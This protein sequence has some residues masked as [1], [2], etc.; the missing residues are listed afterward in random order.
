M[1]QKINP[2]GF[3]VGISEAWKSRWYVNNKKYGQYLLEDVKLRQFLMERLKLA[4]I[5]TVE[6]ERLI[7]QMRLVIHV[8]RPGVVIGRGGS[9]LEELK[10]MIVA[11]IGL[12]EAEKNLR[13]EVVEVKEAD[14]SALLVA[15]RVANELERRF[16]HRRVVNR[17][18][19]RVM[20]AGAKGVKVVVSGRIGGSE[21][22]RREKFSEGSIPLSTIRANIDYASVPAL[23]RSGYIGVKVWI[24][25]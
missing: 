18:I 2:T 23:T 9:G 25:K 4:G 10:K 8:T 16:P 13:I 22:G 1:G 14:L 19:E 12:P 7:N 20:G 15:G 5:V 6:I 17:A 21:I 11:Q 24:Y 3:R